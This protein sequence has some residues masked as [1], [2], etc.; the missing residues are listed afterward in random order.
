MPIIWGSSPKDT[1][2]GQGRR[3]RETGRATRSP[4]AFGWEEPVLAR[5]LRQSWGPRG[6]RTLQAPLY[7]GLRLRASPHAIRILL[8][9][10]VRGPGLPK[11]E[12]R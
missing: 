8:A 9:D 12:V 1:A 7:S 2:C 4:W 3:N 11:K 5:E 10:Q 6:K